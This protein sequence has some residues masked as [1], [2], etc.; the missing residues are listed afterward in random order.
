MI[1]CTL[2]EFCVRILIGKTLKVN[3]N[4]VKLKFIYAFFKITLNS[5]K[6]V[7]SNYMK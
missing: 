3:V 6:Q 2:F 4:K 1:L 7:W 5:T